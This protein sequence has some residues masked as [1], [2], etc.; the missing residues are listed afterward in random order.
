MD[1]VAVM[2]QIL[3]MLLIMGVGLLLR[4][5]G[6]ITAQVIHGISGIVLKVA[7]PSLV[8]MMVQKDG[9]QALKG[10]FMRIALVGFL[11]MS[12]G[13][14][15]VYFLFRKKMADERG[16]AFAGLSALPNV[17][18]MGLPIVQAVYGDLG[19]VYLAAAVVALNCTI[20]LTLETLMTGRLPKLSSIIKNIGLILSVLA[21]VSFML[22]IRLPMPFSAMTAQLGSL[23]TPL[24]MLVAGARLM[25][26]RLLA[27]KDKELWLAVFVRL[28][29]LP[30]AGFVLFRLM[31]F[32][33]VP[34]GVITLACAMPGA[35]STQ[36]YAEREKKDALFA[37]T[38]VSLSTILCLVSI[39]LVLFI[40][41]LGG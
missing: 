35:V 20:Y 24:S 22:D 15:I 34:L 41:G 1:I 19:A 11:W 28:I 18:Y 32:E 13:L 5:A 30:L 33:G 25:D 14:V 8:L 27:L 40:T 21:L 3:M 36:M 7:M 23:T 26:F 6:V 31:G 16:A 29:A 10:E 17:G 12:A 38:G 2:N 39:P 9:G 37:A 4:K